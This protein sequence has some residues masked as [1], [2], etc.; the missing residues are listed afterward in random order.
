MKA[1]EEQHHTV[2]VGGSGLAPL[3]LVVHRVEGHRAPLSSDSSGV[4]GV[5]PKHDPVR[6]ATPAR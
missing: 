3:P 1:G 2:S 6:P 4:G 5:G